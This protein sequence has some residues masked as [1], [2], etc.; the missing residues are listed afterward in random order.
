MW[1]VS[2]VLNKAGKEEGEHGPCLSRWPMFGL[3]LGSLHAGIIILPPRGGTEAHSA[4]RECA[5]E[6][7]RKRQGKSAV[8]VM[9]RSLCAEA[10][11]HCLAYKQVVR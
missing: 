1:C 4:F 5:E 2:N 9:C 7:S 10:M 8:Y 11:C 6:S 3:W